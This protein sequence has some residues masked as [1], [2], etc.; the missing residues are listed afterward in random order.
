MPRERNRRRRK[1]NGNSKSNPDMSGMMNL[2][3]IAGGAYGAYWYITN[4]GP[5]G[6]VKNAA[7]AKIG[8]S[9]WD[10]WF[11]PAPQPAQTALPPGTG[12][13][14]MPNANTGSNMVVPVNTTG[15]VGTGTPTGVPAPVVNTTALRTELL[16]HATTNGAW[17]VPVQSGLTMDQWSY[18]YNLIRPPITGAIADAMVAALGGNRAVLMT[19]DQ[20]IIL[21]QSTGWGLSGVGG[22]GDIVPTGQRISMPSFKGNMAATRAGARI[23]R[24]GATKGWVQ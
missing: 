7:G 23:T 18:S 6:S 15:T 1:S 4:Y 13:V 22:V 11:G 8:P 20:Y 19:V 14:V 9:W 5:G 21:L 17:M 24:A 12:T 16:A 2:V 3:L 10:S